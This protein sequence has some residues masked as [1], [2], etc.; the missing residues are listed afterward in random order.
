MRA[1][2]IG[3]VL[4]LGL[5]GCDP[6]PST[7]TE[8]FGELDLRR[9][10][11]GPGAS[12]S[13]QSI[14]EAI[15]LANSLPHPTT[16]ACFLEA[17]DRPLHI[18]ASKSKASRQPADGARSPRL[19]IFSGD[20]LVITAVLGGDG[21]DLIEFGES[22]APGRTVKG[23]LEFPLAAT[24][25]EDAAY[26]RIRNPEHGN[27]TSCL[28]C[29]DAERDEPGFPGARSSLALRPR[30]KSLVPIESLST[31]L[32]RCDWATQEKRCAMLHAVAGWGPLEH[33][34]FE[35]GLPVF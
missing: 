23:E 29:H 10:K 6:A 5:V 28:V 25:D 12:G 26:A 13:P 1:S 7:T 16:A 8:F 24:L 31:E 17:L 30:T 20:A 9:C 15:V 33:Q 35:Q 11:P 18:E 19:F 3:A 27:I 21:Q 34:A 2:S 4:L 32:T 22:V 14:A